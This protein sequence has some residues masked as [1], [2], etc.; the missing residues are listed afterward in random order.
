LA[1]AV[2]VAS[3]AYDQV[4]RYQGALGAADR[5]THNASIL[6]A[7]ATARSFEDIDATLRTVVL[8]QH[9]I[10]AG[11][12]GRK[13]AIRELLNAIQGSSPVMRAIGWTDAAGNRVASSL[14]PDPPPLNVADQEQ[15]IA[16]RNGAARGLYIA[17]PYYSKLTGDWIIGASRPLES[18][19]GSFAGIA[20]GFVEPDYFAGVFRSLELGRSRV[21]VLLRDDGMVMVREP[22]D[23][24][25]LGR[26]VAA[27]PLF[28][29]HS[30]NDSVG[31]LHGRAFPGD[32]ERIISYARVPGT[33]QIVSVSVTRADALA[34][35]RI[36]LIRGGAR[37][38]FVLFALVAGARLFAVQ[39]R[40]RQRADGEFRDLLEAAPDAMVIVDADGRI[41]LVNAE[42]ERLFGHAR[43]EMLGQSVEMLIPARFHAAHVAASTG[44][45]GAPR[46]R[47]PGSG[48]ELTGLRKD[49]TEFPIEVSLGPLQTEDGM[50]VSSAVRDITAQKRVQAELAGAKLAAEAA[51]RA[52]S[53]FLSR[54]SHELR[55]PLNAVIGFA[56][57][58]QMDGES[59]LS[60]K[61]KE[62]AD[63]IISGGHH[64][65]NLVNEVLDLAGIES[66]R[67][68]LSIE[69]VGV[70]DAV[71][72]V[73]GTMMPLAQKAGL[74]FA[75]TL[76]DGVG[77]VR[78]DELRLRQVL[79]NLVA[80]AI[81]YNRTGGAVTLAAAPAPGERVRF[82]V[83]D[84][85]IGIPAARHKDIFQ[86]FQRL[87]AEY[88]AV[89]GTGIGLAL[90]HHFVQA[91]GGTI[92]FASEA[93]RGSS[94]WI[95]LS[96][97]AAR[98]AGAP[99]PSVSPEAAPR[100]L[101]G[102]FSLLYVEDNPAN[103]RLM[104]HLLSTL[105]NVAM[106][107]APTPQLGL[108]LAIAHRPDVIVLDLNLP[109]MS[110]GE[111]LQRLKG[112]PETGAIPVI[113]LS[114]AAFPRDIKRG[115]EAGFFRYVT[116]P[117]DVGA[118]LSAVDAALA[119]APAR[120]SAIG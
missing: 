61:Q 20:L 80:N 35:F 79:I 88:T 105:P 70:R 48:G 102:G 98:S 4:Q 56:Q 67:I 44:F 8:L 10:A 28:R 96:A 18:P 55:T 66:G 47:P 24:H 115:L 92:G 100:A 36:G 3:F 38:G 93:G 41:V 116:K 112:L 101:A 37:L 117:I 27:A 53:D 64:L 77:D 34:D 63:H 39:L 30:P 43:G 62:Y 107:S 54:M 60:A 120:R 2:I 59:R 40:R 87:G 76:A 12:Y 49:G 65:L 23:E 14:Y 31:T 99:R 84:T 33:R 7:E 15:F 19:D 118:F 69:R 111:L 45:V 95:E 73:Y 11:V 52:K 89:E 13:P 22:V 1:A 82:T 85:G 75:A 58:L 17:A 81:K 6:L 72:A 110:G 78:A 50:L 5:E 74:S 46:L 94:F 51:N 114:A 57:M 9:D 71:D 86:P 109:G 108:E 103:L 21:A 119:D 42:A 68:R 16:Q 104:E 32:R 113:A 29:E 91:M 83:T 26:S 106:L 97:E 90:A 25:R